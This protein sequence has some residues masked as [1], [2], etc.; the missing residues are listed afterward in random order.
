ML[1]PRNNGGR[2]G[3]G[4]HQSHVAILVC[5][6]SMSFYVGEMVYGTIGVSLTLDIYT[7]KKK[8]FIGHR[9]PPGIENCLFIIQAYNTFTADV[10][11]EFIITAE[12]ILNL[13]YFLILMDV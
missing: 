5:M 6:Y 8:V 9:P 11:Y 7:T 4:K 1:G 2:L 3:M 10:K 12:N 13:Y